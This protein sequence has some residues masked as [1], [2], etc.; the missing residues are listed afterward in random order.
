MSWLSRILI[1]CI[2][3]A[4]IAFGLSMLPQAG[5]TEGVPAFQSSRALQISDRSVVD[6]LIKLNISNRIQQ[7]DWNHAT[8]SVDLSMD[9]EAERAALFRDLYEIS[10]SALSGTSNVERVLI[11]VMDRSRIE[12]GT[13]QLVIALDANRKQVPRG[14]KL[15]DLPESTGEYEKYISE[16]FRLTYTVKWKEWFGSASS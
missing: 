10:H 12:E 6:F 15:R 9:A 3:S 7:V 13:P 8:L 11:R 2:I 1:T 14:E 5:G 4:G 16:R